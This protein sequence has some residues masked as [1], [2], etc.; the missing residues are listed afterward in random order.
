[1]LDAA[2][3]WRDGRGTIVVKGGDL[4]ADDSIHTALMISYF[5]DRRAEEG[6]DIPDGTNDRRGYWGDAFLPSPM[7]SRLW[8]LSREK[9]L[10]DALQKA[11]RYAREAV[12]WLLDDELVSA[13]KITATSP[14]K[15][16]LQLTT[17]VTLPDGSKLPPY[18]FTAQL[19][20]I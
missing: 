11:A 15:G 1:M 18:I 6:D 9:Q 10:D 13:I 4:L 20:G 17:D 12:Q 14:A 8:L 5:T 7:G 16:A 2:L 19:L 3:V